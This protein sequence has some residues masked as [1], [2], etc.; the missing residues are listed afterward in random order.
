MLLL[1]AKC[2]KPTLWKDFLKYVFGLSRLQIA[3]IKESDKTASIYNGLIFWHHHLSI[4]PIIG[5]F[6]YVI[7]KLNCNDRLTFL[8]YIDVDKYDDFL[9]HGFGIPYTCHRCVMSRQQAVKLLF[10]KINEWL[11]CLDIANIAVM[12][13]CKSSL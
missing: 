13:V 12:Q 2:I 7:G 6:Y 10:D 1:L 5:T 8:K 4:Y 9:K 11:D 3:S